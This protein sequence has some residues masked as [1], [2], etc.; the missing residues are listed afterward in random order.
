M[1]MTNLNEPQKQEDHL[2][3]KAPNSSYLLIPSNWFLNSTKQRISQGRIGSFKK[4]PT[5]RKKA[6]KGSVMTVG[7]REHC[8]KYLKQIVMNEKT[9]V[10]DEHSFSIGQVE[11]QH[12][13][14]IKNNNKNEETETESVTSLKLN[15]TQE[16][17]TNKHS[18]IEHKDRQQAGFM[19]SRIILG[20]S[21]EN[22]STTKKKK[23]PQ[24]VLLPKIGKKKDN[25]ENL[26]INNEPEQSNQQPSTS[27]TKL[28]LSVFQQILLDDDEMLV[29]DDMDDDFAEL[30]SPPDVNISYR[31]RCDTLQTKII[32]MRKRIKK[33]K[34]EIKNLKVST[35]QRPEP[36]M[37]QAIVALGRLFQAQ[38]LSDE[39]LGQFA[40]AF[41]LDVNQVM[42]AVGPSMRKTARSLIRAK[43]GEQRLSM[44]TTKYGVP[45]KERK[46]IHKFVQLYHPLEAYNHYR[47]EEAMD[48]AIRY[49]RIKREKAELKQH[50]L[51]LTHEQ[52]HSIAAA[53]L[54]NAADND[55]IGSITDSEVTENE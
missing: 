2:I 31:E 45:K 20:V 49:Y 6:H 10:T 47:V 54:N 7:T 23:K 41:G 24:S 34:A 40:Q 52:Q 38:A 5:E 17:R 29:D 37:Q 11:Q 51:Q 22:T 25:K 27:T 39:Q 18:Q 13:R 44:M 4:N 35:M 30:N 14:M 43:Y 15:E 46:L 3:V 33:L 8:E 19:H 28:S 9:D 12:I 21:D 55:D 32:K 1:L 53:S 42:E 50:T 48:S 26:R 16:I 36:E